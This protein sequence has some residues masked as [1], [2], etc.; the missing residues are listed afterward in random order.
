VVISFDITS[1]RRR[2][3]DV[4]RSLEVGLGDVIVDVYTRPLPDGQL[5]IEQ[6]VTN[7][8]KPL[9]IMNFRCTLSVSGHK[10]QTEYVTKIGADKDRKEYKLPNA[11]SLFGQELW[12]NLD[13][14]GGRRNLNKRMIIGDDWKKS[15][16]TP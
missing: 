9:D 8:T 6:F 10:S 3:I 15:P 4:H 5:L 16:A 2:T 7:R 1:D 14:I 12:L 13:Q 11:Q